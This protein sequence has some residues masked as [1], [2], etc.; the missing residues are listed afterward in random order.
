VGHYK[1]DLDDPHPTADENE[2]GLMEQISVEGEG[3]RDNMP[4]RDTADESVSLSN[5]DSSEDSN[6]LTTT[7]M[8]IWVQKMEKAAL[9]M[10]RT[11]KGMPLCNIYHCND[12]LL[13]KSRKER[14]SVLAQR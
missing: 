12:E 9:L 6:S 2:N 8:T 1:V 3:T 11:R 10:K 5:D 13:Q 14:S 4:S 7:K